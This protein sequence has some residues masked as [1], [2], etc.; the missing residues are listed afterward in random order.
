MI[1]FIY[2]FFLITL[3]ITYYMIVGPIYILWWIFKLFI[4]LVFGFMFQLEVF[5]GVFNAKQAMREE[6]GFSGLYGG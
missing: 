1:T 6:V 3:K 2:Y 4:K 5:L